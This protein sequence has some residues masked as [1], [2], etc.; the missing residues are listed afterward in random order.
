MGTRTNALLKRDNP[1]QQN[2]THVGL[3]SEV[4]RD[5]LVDGL[6]T[7]AVATPGSSERN[8]DILVGVLHKQSEQASL[9][10]R[11]VRTYKSDFVKCVDVED[12]V[13]RRGR[14]LDVRLHAGFCGDA[15]K[16]SAGR[17]E[18]IQS[19]RRVSVQSISI[20]SSERVQRP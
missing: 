9:Q 13:R 11:D 15:R 1:K 2:N 8:D 14:R 3:V 7:L 4:L 16:S 10:C 5:L 20:V 19:M 6:Q 17:T 12:L 18:A